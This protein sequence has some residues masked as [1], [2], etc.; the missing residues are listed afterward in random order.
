MINAGPPFV[1]CL[2]YIFYRKIMKKIVKA[3]TVVLTLVFVLCSCSNGVIVQKE[4]KHRPSTGE[5]WTVML[6][7]CGSTLEENYKQGSKVLESLA[8]DL[9][10]NINVVVETGGSRLW[11]QEDVDPDYTQD[12]EVQK[13][14][15]RLVNQNSSKNMGE[16]ST[17]K[18]F[19][20]WGIDTYPADHYIAVVWNHGGGPVGGTAYDSANNFDSLTIPELSYVMS[21]LSEKIDLIGF[22][23][24]LMSNLETAS[25]LAL[26]ADY[27]VASEDVM[28]MC[29]WD[30]QG[31]LDFIS[32]CPSADV[33]QV[34]QVICEGVKSAVSEQE[35]EL[36]SMAVTDLSKAT[37]LSLAFEG[38]ARTM[39]SAADD[40]TMLRNVVNAMNELEYM[41]GNSPWE[42]YSNL[43]DIGELTNLVYEHIGGPAANIINAIN[44]MVIYRT[45]SD[46]HA[47]SSG[48]SVYYPVHRDGEQLGKYRK[49]CISNS[50]M[51]FLEKM[52][53]NTEIPDR[54][55]TPENSA[56]WLEYNSLAYNN[57]MTASPD[58]NGRYILTAT[59]PQILTRAGVNYYMY[60]P[61]NSV[62]LYL[63]RDYNVAL[64]SASGSYMYEISGRLPMLNSTPVSMYL[65]SQNKFYDI[66]S[67]PVVYDGALANL[68]VSK[69]KR[70]E[71][72]GEYEI[73]GIWKGVDPYSSMAERK[74]TELGT[75]D[76]IIPVY[77]VYGQDEGS[78]VEGHKIRIGF[79]GAKITEKPI[80]EGDYIVSYTAEDM[81]GVS[82]ECDT[83]NL[84][85]TK[86]TIK[87]MDY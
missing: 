29:G 19:L 50:Y 17:L 42:G 9:P 41:G 86:G 36:V 27:M 83:N 31:L 56:V 80:G 6:Y 60:S 32:N 8:Y 12:Y 51:E 70:V 1:F 24:S 13:N 44:E 62:Y 71:N 45:M 59:S 65:V 74:Y 20:Q 48:L 15:L 77:R 38:M 47:T 33:A 30:Y 40:I 49:V 57:V 34:G 23:A 28:P 76:I 69:S 55:F 37:M 53:I 4:A 61:E 3:F 58:M 63:F 84:V 35:K 78:Y 81:Y 5:K 11:H 87:I 68:R 22:D 46:Y 18:K 25:S 26:Y 43:I 66:Y 75:G 10:E 14:G 54:T 85:S 52:C 16:S 73:L 7:M 2:S 67:I 64:D 21:G 79:G 82:Y 72:A 39:V